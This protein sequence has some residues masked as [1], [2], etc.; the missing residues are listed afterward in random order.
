MCSL[1][2]M[3]FFQKSQ[4]VSQKPI[5]ENNVVLHSI[6]EPSC[7]FYD[8]MYAEFVVIEKLLKIFL[9]SKRSVN[10][11]ENEDT[12]LPVFQSWNTPRLLELDINR[13][14]MDHNSVTS[15]NHYLKTN[16]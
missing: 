6:Q 3:F 13:F 4:K 10:K 1:K 8:R 2:K 14:L 11:N 12:M 9:Q 16:M 15:M 7:I 5:S